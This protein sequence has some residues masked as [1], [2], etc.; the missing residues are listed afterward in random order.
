MEATQNRGKKMKREREEEVG[1]AGAAMSPSLGLPSTVAGASST[2]RVFLL[3]RAMDGPSA[4]HSLRAPSP[5]VRAMRTRLDPPPPP[6][7]AAA[8]TP[9]LPPPPQMPEK[10]RRG[11]PRNCDR[12]LPPPGFLLTPPARAPPSPTLATHGE[13]SWHF[14]S[15][16]LQPHVLKID[17]GEDI[18]SKIVGF[19]KITGKAVCVLSVLGVVQEANLLH[20]SVTLNHKGP[21]EII[22]VFGSILTSDSPGFGCLS[23]A[24]ACA[25]C[26]VIGGVV[27]GPL[28]AAIPA[29]VATGYWV[30]HYPNSQV[31]TGFAVTHYPNSHVATVTGCKPCPSSQVAA[32]TGSLCCLNSEVAIGSW[33][34]HDH[35][36]QVSIGDWN[37]S[38]N[39]SNS[40]VTV[41]DGSTHHPNSHT[42][43]A[44]YPSSQVPICNG[45]THESSSRVTVGD[46]STSNTSSQATVG[47]GSRRHQPDSHDTVAN[48][49]ATIGHGGTHQPNSQVSVGEGSTDNANSQAT[50]GDGSTHYLKSLAAA[51]GDGS[52]GKGNS[53]R[54][55]VDG[56]T[57]CP[58]F[59]VSAGAGR[60]QY[61]NS[62]VTVGDGSNPSTEG[63]NLEDAS[64]TAV[65][66]GESS[67]ID[68]KPSHVVAYVSSGSI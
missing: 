66:K 22:H 3:T 33:S 23:V 45:S 44:Q 14:Q 59:K 58:N 34:K 68:V 16:G 27:A 19:S 32:S 52:T 60:S 15:G 18:V 65:E 4:F 54:G 36:S 38:T 40:Q 61:P 20:S 46:G 41:G 37:G 42:G 39:H 5:F 17:V 12:V 57:N 21:L 35:N 51:V 29:Q 43:S 2:A 56:N 1:S 26:S 11:R 64:C 8:P 7:L 55:L 48:S 24:L 49:R 47:D 28:V 13:A 30:T 6:P 31:G 53:Q 67:E 63:S 62:Q 50:V 9:P 10:R 25:D